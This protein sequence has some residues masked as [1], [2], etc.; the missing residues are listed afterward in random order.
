M[1]ARHRTGV[2]R[3]SLFGWVLW[4]SLASGST[5]ESTRFDFAGTQYHYRFSA[6]IAAPM[7]AVRA[8][9]NDVDQLARTNDSIRISRVLSRNADGSWVRQLRLR[10]CVLVFCFDIDFVELV[11]EE[12][13]GDLR[14]RVLPGRGNFRQGDTV[15]QLT[16]LTDGTTRMVMESRQ[17]P[18]FWIPP[19]I[20]PLIMKRTFTHEVE[21][22][23]VNIERLARAHA[24]LR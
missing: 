8:V 18:D 13:N 22:T 15:W 11:Q 3:C 4:S 23:I 12:P 20:G 16:P 6:R 24:E 5:L 14:T 2:A 17:E 10:Q 21:E 19:V 1:S 9:V 7:P